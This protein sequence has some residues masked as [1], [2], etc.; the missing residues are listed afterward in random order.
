[1]LISPFSFILLV[2][3]ID[4]SNAIAIDPNYKWALNNKGWAL[5]NLGNYTGAIKFY[6]RALVIDPKLEV[7]GL[8]RN[9]YVFSPPS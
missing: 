9:R 3:T 6:D 7:A 1:M 4:K 2:D 8:L 5:Y